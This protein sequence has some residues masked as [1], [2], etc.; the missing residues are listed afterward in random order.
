[1]NTV[2]QNP[3][4]ELEQLLQEG[5]FLNVP[6]IGDLISGTVISTKGREIRIDVSGLT[7]GVIRGRELFAETDVLRDLKPGDTVEAT[8]VDLENENGEMELSFRYAGNKKSWE[9]LQSQFAIGEP[10]SVK[11]LDANKGG[12]IVKAKHISGFLP[13]SQLAPEHY[14]RVSGGDKQKILDK[15]REF[16]GQS[17]KVKILDLNETDEK[18]IVSEKAIWEGEQRSVITQISV[19]KQI[20]GEI[21]ALA[22]FGAFVKFYPA[23]EADTTLEGLV[24]ISEIAW[25]RIDHPRD[26]LKVGQ[27]VKAQI[28]G[29][30]GSKIFLSIKKL[31]DDPWTGVENRYKIGDIVEGT[32]LKINPFGFFVE[33]DKDIHGLAHVSELS[34]KPI[35]DMSVLGKIN[36]VRKFKIV[37]IEPKEHRLGLSIKAMED[38]VDSEEKE[39]NADTEVA[40]VVEHPEEVEF[41]KDLHETEE[42]K[43]ETEEATSE[44]AGVTQ[45]TGEVNQDAEE[46]TTSDE[47]VK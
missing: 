23:P 22:D 21:T 14:P 11:V 39:V 7:T 41:A 47:E 8:V 13:V 35:E 26:L 9:D 25:Q 2:T 27:T 16:V 17:I 6:N 43:A 1:M 24:H 28:I 46:I 37:S 12:L 10:I 32:I 44:G 20:E 15:L 4:S 45:N 42:V 40:G 33:L 38:K 36:Q 3:T 29:I 5:D 30:E 34:S 19:G 31:M 18:L